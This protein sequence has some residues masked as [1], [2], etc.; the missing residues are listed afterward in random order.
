L[1]IYRGLSRCPT[2]VVHDVTYRIVASLEILAYTD[3]TFS[4]CRAAAV[5]DIADEAYAAMTRRSDT[6]RA[7]TPLLA[8][9]PSRSLVWRSE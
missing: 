8:D 1:P 9:L 5:Q 6:I 2:V 3:G 4:P 7:P